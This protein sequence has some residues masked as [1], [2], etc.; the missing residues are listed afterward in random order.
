MPAEKI[1]AEPRKP[2]SGKSTQQHNPSNQNNQRDILVLL[3]QAVKETA[4]TLG[5]SC[6][7]SSHNIWH[8]CSPMQSKTTGAS[9][10]TNESLA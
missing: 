1:T 4:S 3:G 5:S 9:H 8:T 2:Q 6:I 7:L 10:Q